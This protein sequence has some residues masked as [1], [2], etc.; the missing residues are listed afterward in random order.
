MKNPDSKSDYDG[1]EFYGINDLSNSWE[2]K[3]AETVLNS[4]NPDK[5]MKI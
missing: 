2:L 5:N 3:K 1:V 4:F